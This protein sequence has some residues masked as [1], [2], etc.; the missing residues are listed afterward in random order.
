MQQ[1]TLRSI[2]KANGY[3][4]AKIAMMQCYSADSGNDQAWESLTMPGQF[5]GYQGMNVGG[6]DMRVF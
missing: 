6:V 3:K 5:I 1:A 4:L 2:V